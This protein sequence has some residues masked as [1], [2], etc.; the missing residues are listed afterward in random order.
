MEFTIENI[1]MGLIGLGVVI[2][3]AILGIAWY[4]L[5]GI[6]IG[7]NS[8]SQ[9]TKVFSDSAKSLSL[10]IKALSL[11]LSALGQDIKNQNQNSSALSQNI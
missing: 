1:T 10:D 6:H 5:R 2:L 9:D 7:I 8:L 11:S 3:A 4:Y